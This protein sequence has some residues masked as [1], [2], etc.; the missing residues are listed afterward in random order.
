MPLA[1]TADFVYIFIACVHM[2]VNFCHA[3]AEMKRKKKSGR[4]ARRASG[5]HNAQRI[6]LLKHE[7]VKKVH[8]ASETSEKKICS[9]LGT[10][11]ERQ[12]EQVGINRKES[13]TEK[14]GM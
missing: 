2:N 11:N 8:T 5:G 14:V 3:T 12:V 13:K 1:A 9:L 10:S 6:H 7:R 4:R